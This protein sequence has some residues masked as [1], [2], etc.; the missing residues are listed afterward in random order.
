MLSA[1]TPAW[2]LAIIA[3]LS[4]AAMFLTQTARTLGFL[5]RFRDEKPLGC[6]L[7]MSFWSTAAAWLLSARYFLDT[8]PLHALSAAACC[9]LLLRRL[10]PPQLPPMPPHGGSN[11]GDA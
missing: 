8:T 9:F 3:M 1:A 11:Q 10:P 4:L 5:E 6:D 7:C 2:S